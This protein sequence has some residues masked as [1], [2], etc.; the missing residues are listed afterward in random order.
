[1]PELEKPDP[2]EGL[3]ACQLELVLQNLQAEKSRRYQEKER[4]GETYWLQVIAPE[5][6]DTSEREREILA[7]HL[8]HCPQDRAKQVQWIRRIIVSPPPIDPARLWRGIQAEPEAV[9][10]RETELEPDQPAPKTYFFISTENS[11]ED[12]SH[13]GRIE[14]GYYDLFDG[15]VIVTDRKG[16]RIG[17]APDIGNPVAVARTILRKHIADHPKPLKVPKLGLV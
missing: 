9:V 4:K 2:L 12:G 11:A 3:T 8:R 17:S 16:L 14:E 10:K 13:A 7:E 6:E 1:M 5:G 15:V